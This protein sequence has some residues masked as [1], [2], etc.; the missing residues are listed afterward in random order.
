MSLNQVPKES[1]LKLLNPFGNPTNTQ[2]ITA[3]QTPNYPDKGVQFAGYAK[4]STSGQGY[5]FKRQNYQNYSLTSQDANEVTQQRSN[6]KTHNFYCTD[7]FIQYSRVPS[8]LS[9][10]RAISFKDNAISRFV[11]YII[12]SSWRSA[13]DLDLAWSTDAELGDPI[14]IYETGLHLH[15]SVPIPFEDEN[16]K[17]TG[18]GSASLMFH[19]ELTGFDEEK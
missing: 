9:T 12:Y 16:I 3:S 2:V 18:S 5:V 19:A 17:M 1:A 8:N 13:S 4:V 15:F 14:N 11:F 6:F 10:P 7:I